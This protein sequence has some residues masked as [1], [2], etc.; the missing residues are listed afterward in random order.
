MK[1]TCLLLMAVLCLYSWQSQAQIA[2]TTA[3]YPLPTTSAASGW[4]V[5]AGSSTLQ[6]IGDPTLGGSVNNFYVHCWDEGAQYSPSAGGL[7]WRVTN[8]G[9]GLVNQGSIPMVGYDIDVALFK[10]PDGIIRVLAAY[11]RAASG[12]YTGG[13]F[14][15]IYRI[16]GGM[17]VPESTVNMLAPTSWYCGGINV[18]ANIEDMGLAITWSREG[19]VYVVAA[20]NDA[21]FGSPVY[22]PSLP[23]YRDPDVAIG[24]H[25]AERNLYVVARETNTIR[26]VRLPFDAV[27]MGGGTPAT[28]DTY[29]SG[30]PNGMSSVPRIDCPDRFPYKKW[31]VVFGELSYS[32]GVVLEYIKARIRNVATAVPVMPL[33]V[34]TYSTSG[35]YNYI[36][37][38][39]VLAYYG[40]A[41]TIQVGWMSRHNSVASGSIGNN[42]R[43]LGESVED[44]GGSFP[45][46]I[47]NSYYYIDFVASNSANALAFS[48]QNLS[49]NFDGMHT[50]FS[51]VGT[52]FPG[53]SI[54]YKNK[55]WSTVAFRPANPDDKGSSYVAEVHNASGVRVYPNPFASQ[56]T[57]DIP[58]EGQYHI[59][60]FTIDGRK[61]YEKDGQ[62]N[63]GEKLNI[64]TAQ[65]GA[66]SYFFTIAAPALGIDEKV[67]LVK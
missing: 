36:P 23:E 29:T 51:Q 20:Y 16:S 54:M 27:V 40:S 2:A 41:D 33:T 30:P 19:Q 42:G 59:R 15:D 28:E 46:V 11:F 18:D 24:A 7:A 37:P 14:Y 1:K 12:G 17:L 45:N 22:I 66:G 26:T 50:V 44:I 39:P 35:S 10:G 21:I 34:R 58:S 53:S 52:V 62:F 60:L 67:K 25:G 48:G 57:I 47:L 49:S 31:A 38:Q 63:T 13:Y 3:E 6:L 64:P 8:A 55:P 9:G 4:A 65:L 43:Y 5:N 56:V 61:V 32:G